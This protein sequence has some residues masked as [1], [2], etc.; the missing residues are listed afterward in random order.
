MKQKQYEKRLDK[1]KQAECV[2][3]MEEF[4]TGIFVRQ[5]PICKHVF[6]SKCLDHWIKSREID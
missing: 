2:I 4:E 5:V 6:H 1:Y 3:C